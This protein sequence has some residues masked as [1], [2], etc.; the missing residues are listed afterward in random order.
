MSC[1]TVAGKA[2]M[3]PEIIVDKPPNLAEALASRFESEGGR[4]LAAK[5]RFA[6]ALPGGS[7]ATAFFPRLA[8]VPFDWSRTEFFWGDERAVPPSDPESNYGL[9]RSLWLEPAAVPAERIHRM[10][11]DTPDPQ[12]AAAS[13]AAELVRVLGTPPRLDFVLL[14]VGPDGHV[15]SLF[16]G[17]ALLREQRRWVAPIENAPKPPS[18]R[19]TATLPLLTNAELVVVA[20]LGIAKAEVLREAIEQPASS[21]PLALVMRATR[22]TVVLI[23]AAAASS[24][25]GARP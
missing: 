15:C 11:A 7:V 21:L 5:G 4:A 22:R 14:G 20:A 3:P 16:P 10:D 24:L 18:R 13:Y 8:R 23:D 12:G 19:L 17:H 1:S 6:V 25:S 2:N 9:A